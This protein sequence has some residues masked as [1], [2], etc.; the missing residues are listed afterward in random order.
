MQFDFLGMP[1]GFWCVLVAL[2]FWCWSLRIERRA[3]YFGVFVD[4]EYI[5]AYWLRRIGFWIF[6]TGL[7]VMWWDIIH[8]PLPLFAILAEPTP[9]LAFLAVLVALVWGSEVRQKDWLL[10]KRMAAFAREKDR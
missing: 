2:F 7:A 3:D 6:E 10:K 4:D 8:F 1:T 9:R 5:N